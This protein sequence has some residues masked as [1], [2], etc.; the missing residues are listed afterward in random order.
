MPSYSIAAHTRYIIKYHIVWIVKYR[1]DILA[2]VAIG[3]A[4]NKIIREI[5]ERY[6]FTIISLGTDGDHIH[7]FVSAPAMLS[8]SAAVAFFIVMNRSPRSKSSKVY[9]E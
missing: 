4:V 2:D 1:H 8:P 6:G 9:D 5:A 3:D 7:V